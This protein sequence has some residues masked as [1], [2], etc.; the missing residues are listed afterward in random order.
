VEVVT[1]AVT[2]LSSDRAIT[3][4]FGNSREAQ[5]FCAADSAA[6]GRE[7]KHTM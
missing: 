1:H 6:G 2:L 4:L 5:R 3:E 7:T